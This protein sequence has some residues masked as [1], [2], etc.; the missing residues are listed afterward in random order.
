ME[1]QKDPSTNVLRL[2]DDTAKYFE[3]MLAK[4]DEFHEAMLKLAVDSSRRERQ[5]ESDR[6]DANRRDDTEA[7][8]IA[9]LA[10]DK[11]AEVLATQMVENANTLREGMTKTAETIAAQLQQVTTSLDSR[12]KIVEEKQFSFAGASKGRGDMWGWVLSAVLALI[13][14]YSFLSK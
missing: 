5:Q 8:K 12:L 2:V 3:K 11:K 9:N 4:Q 14:V 6:I 10:A 1:D 7:V 13:T